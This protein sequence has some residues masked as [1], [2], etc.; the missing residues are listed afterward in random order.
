MTFLYP[1]RVQK[2]ADPRRLRSHVVIMAYIANVIAKSRQI[3]RNEPI[4]PNHF[5]RVHRPI[6]LVA[7]KAVQQHQRFTLCRTAFKIGPHQIAHCDGFFRKLALAAE[8]VAE[9]RI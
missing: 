6:V 1:H 2:I 3:R 9:K 8:R 7:A 5:G 4:F